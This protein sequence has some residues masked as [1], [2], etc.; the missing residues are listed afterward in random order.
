M[1]NEV[2]GE[3][4]ATNLRMFGNITYTPIEGLDIKYLVSSNTYNQTRGYYETQN[5]KSTWRDGKMVTH[6]AEQQKSARSIRANSSMEENTT[7]RP[8][9]HAIGRL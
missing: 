8:F 6:L 4:Q 9:I 3:N 5:H 2:E 7:R 1:L